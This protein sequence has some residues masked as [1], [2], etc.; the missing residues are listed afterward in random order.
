LIAHLL[1]GSKIAIGVRVFA[2]FIDC[3]WLVRWFPYSSFA[4]GVSVD[5]Q[6]MIAESDGSWGKFAF[7]GFARGAWSRI[8]G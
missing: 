3:C 7:L 5:S 8:M 4:K 1:H 6:Q 2:A